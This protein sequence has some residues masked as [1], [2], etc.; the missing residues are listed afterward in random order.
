MQLRALG[1][2]RGGWIFVDFSKSFAV[3]V[4]AHRFRESGQKVI[5]DFQ[6]VAYACETAIDKP[7]LLLRADLGV[8]A[9]STTPRA[10]L[11]FKLESLLVVL[12]IRKRAEM[13]REH[14]RAY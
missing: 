5:A 12:E 11:N 9:V 13:G 14:I 8:C 4:I 1:F 10:Y 6:A 2:V 7:Q 3:R